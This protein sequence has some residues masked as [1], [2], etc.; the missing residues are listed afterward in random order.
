MV[1]I[2]ESIDKKRQ[3]IAEYQSQLEKTSDYYQSF[4]L[5]KARLRGLQGSCE[6]AEAFQEVLMPVQGPFYHPSPTVKTIF[7]DF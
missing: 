2:S 5:Q 7:E 4:N 1:D 3:A 6:Y